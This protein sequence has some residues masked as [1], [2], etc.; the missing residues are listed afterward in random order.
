MRHKYLLP[1]LSMSQGMFELRTATN[2]LSRLKN[3]KLRFTEVKG[4]W[5]T[6][7]VT[8]D[9]MSEYIEYESRNSIKPGSPNNP[10]F[11][12]NALVEV[13]DIKATMLISGQYLPLTMRDFLIGV[14]YDCHIE[15]HKVAMG[16]LNVSLAH[17]VASDYP[18]SDALSYADMIAEHNSNVKHK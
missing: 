9:V 10:R 3:V 5:V 12:V 15:T 18:P 14:D 16:N 2:I 1:A 11:V 8:T 7:G 4:Y 13:N 6:Y 17:L